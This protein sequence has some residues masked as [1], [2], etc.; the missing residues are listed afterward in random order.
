MYSNFIKIS[1][2][3]IKFVV[4]CNLSSYLSRFS[5]LYITWHGYVSYENMRNINIP[6][7]LGIPT[8]MG[9]E[10]LCKYL[11]DNWNQI[12]EYFKQK[13]SGQSIIISR[14]HIR[15]I[16]SQYA[17]NITGNAWSVVRHKLCNNKEI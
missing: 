11:S 14:I 15:K 17:W 4:T 5:T 13:T 8:P 3:S 7:N 10:L 1:Y 12:T 2:A 9:H 16:L 6:R